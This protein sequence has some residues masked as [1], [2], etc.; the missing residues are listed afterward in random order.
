MGLLSETLQW[1]C[2]LDVEL[3]ACRCT[4]G[5][6]WSYLCIAQVDTPVCVCESV[7]E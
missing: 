2:S 5:D 7:S 1:W 6:T 3:L 4:C